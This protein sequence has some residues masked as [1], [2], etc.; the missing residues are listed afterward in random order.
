MYFLLGQFDGRITGGSRTKRYSSQD[1][2]QSE[3]IVESH[4]RHQHEGLF[5]HVSLNLPTAN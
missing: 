3:R 1:V 4:G 2:Q 5:V